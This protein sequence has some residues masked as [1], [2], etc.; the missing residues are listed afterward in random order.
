MDAS[1]RIRLHGE[2]EAVE[3]PMEAF[4]MAD[5]RARGRIDDAGEYALDRIDPDENEVKDAWL[6]SMADGT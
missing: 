4:S 1:N 5:E 6:D 2:G 3:V